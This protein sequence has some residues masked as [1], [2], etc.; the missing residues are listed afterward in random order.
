MFIKVLTLVFDPILGGFNDEILRDFLKDCEV[1][2]IREYFFI[3]N[4]KPYMTFVIQ[5]STLLKALNPKMNEKKMDESWKNLLTEADIGIF[6]ILREWRS[7]KAK[8]EGLPPYLLFTNEQ[9]AH[10]VRQRPQSKTD[11]L[12]INGVGESKTNKYGDEILRITIIQVE[13]ETKSPK[14]KNSKE[15]ENES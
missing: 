6:N 3:K 12:K 9:L 2:S 11:L 14:T 15:D 5:Y 7:N 8:K 1:I 4:E 10:I 13:P